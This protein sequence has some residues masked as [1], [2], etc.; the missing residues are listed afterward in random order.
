MSAIQ[1]EIVNTTLKVVPTAKGSYQRLELIFKNKSYQDKVETKP[2]MDFT[3]KEVF[4]LLK[5]AGQGDIFTI[6]RE[7]D[8]KGFWQWVKCTSG[9][10][11]IKETPSMVATPSPKGNW[12]TSEERAQRQ[13][14]IVRQSSLSNA[15][16]LLTANGGKKNTVGEV[17]DIARM[18]EDY[19]LHDKGGSTF[20]DLE[21]DVPL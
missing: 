19:V 8:E 9:V 5:N 17:I 2:I 4:N 20:D 12:E 11:E 6:D 10:I 15:V 1:I 3:S 7:K 21:E 13:I 16:A 18:F 14:M